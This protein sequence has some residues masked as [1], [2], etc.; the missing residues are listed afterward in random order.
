MPNLWTKT[1]Q[2]IYEAFKGPRTVDMEF[3]G[4][5]EEIKLIVSQIKNISVT[6]KSFPQKLMGFK[7]LCTEICQHL[8]KP[9]PNDNIFYPQINAIILAHKDMINC[10]QECSTTLNNLSGATSEWQKLFSEVKEKLKQ[11]EEARKVHALC[12]WDQDL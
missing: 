1:T 8:I 9:Y 7:D 5:Y 4:K 2:I 12:S 6:I 3:N 11:R 10:Y